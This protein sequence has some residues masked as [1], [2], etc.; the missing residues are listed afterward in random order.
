MTESPWMTAAADFVPEPGLWI[1][2]ELRDHA[3]A[4]VLPLL[5]PRD[6]STLASVPSAGDAEVDDAVAVAVQTF[7]SG[8]WS[9]MGPTERGQVLQRWADLIA[10][11]SEEL[12]LVISLE[13]GKPVTAA[14][15]VEARAAEK[16]IRWY[17]ELSDK[18]M[19][20]APRGRVDALA[21]VTREPVGCVAA[22]LPWNMP[23]TLLSWKLGAALVAGNSMVV[24]PAEQTPLSAVLLARWAE[25][26]GLPTGVLNVVTGEGAVAGRRLALHR[27]VACLTFTGSPRVGKQLLAY[28]AESNAKPVW[29]ELGGKTPFMVLADADLDAASDALAWGITFNTGQL[30]SAA[31]RA[32]VAQEV[33][34][35]FVE[36][37][38]AKL[39]KR[40]VGDPLDPATEIGPLASSQ[41]RDNVL[42]HVR[43]GMESGAR[44]ALG[45]AEKDPRDGW[46]VEPAVFTGVDASNLLAQEEIFGPV[47]SVLTAES[48][49]DA[50]RLANDSAYGLG[51]SVW[52]SDISSAHQ[53]SRRIDAGT[54]WVNCFEE[55][56]MSVPFGGRKLSGHG[57]DKSAHAIDKFTHLKTTWIAL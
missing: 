47:L 1:G 4:G 39:A 50:V 48:L 54:V 51:S 13:M 20:E 31:S 15:E 7:T 32:I 10:E 8:I 3:S 25:E 19:D 11:R 2:G 38:T 24:K 22:I 40:V 46:Y 5:T 21:L 29:L 43:R 26:A 23:V 49:D 6:G 34:E 44:L 35:E 33:A 36:S 14:L 37:V 27:D 56:D 53:V 45:S 41:H 30:C 16:T 9:R 12:A 28:A 18:L 57:A 17:G 42:A 52:T 55:G